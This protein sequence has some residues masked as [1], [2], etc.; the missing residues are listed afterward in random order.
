MLLLA[1]GCMALATQ[2]IAAFWNYQPALGEPWFFAGGLP[3]YAPWSALSWHSRFAAHDAYGFMVGYD[4]AIGNFIVGGSFGYSTGDFEDK[5]ATSDDSEIDNY[6]FNAYLNYTN[7]CG[8]FGTLVGGYTLSDHN[9]NDSRGG[10]G[11]DADYNTDT[12]YVAG[13]LG[14]N[15]KP[16]ENFTIAPSIGVGYVNSRAD[17]HD[18]RFAGVAVQRYSRFKSDTA[19]LPVEL[20]ARYDWNLNADTTVN[21][22]AKGGYTY[23]FDADGATGNMTL[24]GVDNAAVVSA[25]SREY[26]HSMWNLGAGVG[27]SY[28]RFDFGVNY[29][30]V[31]M[32]EFASHRISATA[33]ISF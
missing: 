33:G 17:A 20:R 24:L 19:F 16:V 21:F 7:A 28:K 18:A 27:V 1:L 23:N 10:L 4:R 8:I 32:K 30:Y 22:N 15:I 29:D 25:A 12:W 6:S 31:G 3:W 2:R 26:G 11:Y 9:M 14:Y 5:S 13:K